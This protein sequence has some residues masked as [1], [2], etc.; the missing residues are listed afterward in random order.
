MS[1]CSNDFSLTP[2]LHIHR[3][4]ELQTLSFHLSNSGGNENNL[5]LKA[6]KWVKID[7]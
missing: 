6:K 4:G 2:S 7:S 3:E 1:E 5:P